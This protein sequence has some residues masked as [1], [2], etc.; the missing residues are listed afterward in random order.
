MIRLTTFFGRAC[1]RLLV[2][3]QSRPSARMRPFVITPEFHVRFASFRSRRRDPTVF[4]LFEYHG[5]L[6]PTG[7][8]VLPFCMGLRFSAWPG[9]TREGWGGERYRVVRACSRRMQVQAAIPFL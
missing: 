1:S 7:V 2:P 6:P 5:A 4:L 9:G 8:A 3:P